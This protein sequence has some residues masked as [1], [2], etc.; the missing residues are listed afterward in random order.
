MLPID[1]KTQYEQ[2]NLPRQLSGLLELSVI[3]PTPSW[4]GLPRRN[5]ELE[6]SPYFPDTPTDAHSATYPFP[7][8]GGHHHAHAKAPPDLS[9]GRTRASSAFVPHHTSHT[10][11]ESP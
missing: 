1:S 9:E 4:V 10:L 8:F 5:L 11:P 2:T 3:P 7:R 6:Q